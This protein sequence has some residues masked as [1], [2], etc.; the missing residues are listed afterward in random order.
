MAMMV[1]KSKWGMHKRDFRKIFLPSSP[2]K[3][4]KKKIDSPQEKSGSAIQRKHS[5]KRGGRDINCEDDLRSRNL[6]KSR[7][8]IEDHLSVNVEKP[9]K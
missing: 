6:K 8:K 1:I 4:P 5:E 2:A 3:G 9:A 7:G